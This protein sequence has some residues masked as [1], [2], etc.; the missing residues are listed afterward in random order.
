MGTGAV[1]ISLFGNLRASVEGV[2]I[3]ALA[4][5]RLQS[6]LAW[7]VLHADQ[8]APKEH[9][10]FLLWPE[11][12]GAQART[13]LRQLLHH[14][15]RAFPEC[16][17]LLRVD[18][19]TVQWR[20]DACCT[21]DVI[22]FASLVDLAS[23]A[24]QK[25][26]AESELQALRRAARL[27]VDDVMPAALDEWL[28]P[29]RQA[30]RT[31]LSGALLR[32]ASLVEKSGDLADAMTIAERLV[33]HEPT[34]ET[35]YQLL[36]R[37]QVANKDRASAVRT[38]HRCK[39]VLR[40]ELGM[41]P[42]RATVTL[43]EGL[44][45]AKVPERSRQAS[46]VQ[47]KEAEDLLIG[48]IPEQHEMERAWTSAMSGSAC[49]VLVSGE[50]GIGKTRLA[51]AFL[52]GA[53]RAGHAVVRSRCHVGHGQVAYAPVAQWLRSDRMR[54][55]WKGASPAQ[56]VELARLLPEISGESSFPIKEQVISDSW[57]KQHLY[58]ALGAAFSGIARPLILFVDDLHWCDTDSLEWLQ[59]MFTSHSAQRL[60]VI[61]TV[62]QE[63]VGRDHPLAALRIGLRQAD[64]LIDIPLRPLDAEES[65]K[66]ARQTADGLRDAAELDEVYRSTK[67]NPLFIVE[68]MRAGLQSTRIHAVISAR[69]ASLSGVSYELAGLA[70]V[71]GRSFSF[72]L[73]EKASDWDERSLSQALDELWQRRIIESR[74]GAEYDFTHDQLR[75]V[76]KL[77]LSPVRLRYVH[78][79]L[80]R[81][82]SEVYRNDIQEWNGQ[83]AFHYEQAGMVEQAIDHLYAA[84]G[85]ARH[86][87][88]Y[89]DSALLLRRALGLLEHFAE[90]PKRLER[91]LDLLALLGAALVTT[92]GY[93]AN[94]VGTTFRRAL[95][96][97]RR[98][99]GKQ[100]FSF[101][102]G[103][104]FFHVVRGEIEIS[105]QEAMEFLTAA[106][107]TSSSE[108]TLAGHFLLGSSLSH[109][110]QL[111]SS[112][113]HLRLALQ[114]HQE[115]SA[116]VLEVFGG[117]DARV[118]CQAYLSHLAWHRASNDEDTS[119]L[120]LVTDAV[121]IADSM[122]HPF[123]QAIALNYSALLHA[124]MSD[125][126][127]ALVV[128]RQAMELCNRN[129]FT[130]YLAMAS[131]VTA[132]AMCASGEAT[133][134]LEQFLSGLDVMR[135]LGAELRLPFY[136]ALLAQ[137]YGRFG[138]LREASASLATGFAFAGK[139]GE[140]WATSELH[141]IQG[142][143]LQAEGR[144]DQASVS[145]QRA[146]EAAQHCG[147]LAF[148][149]RLK[150]CLQRTADSN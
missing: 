142:D 99:G 55:C 98:L 105:R 4:T 146:L 90:S 14:L 80:A 61:G 25:D 145:Y 113:G 129:G 88:A 27:Y 138:M 8:P 93:S 133:A 85:L 40:R 69:L 127:S 50:P 17:S 103:Y 1:H 147:S 74:D 122:R 130:Y 30:M 81:A 47:G 68:T 32:L 9:L 83:I 31:Q 16:S 60:L 39:A 42:D 29:V 23:E 67:G 104:W 97:S 53:E 12:S 134:G 71:V 86:R 120:T 45:H 117:P 19:S 91:E 20:R 63:E 149:R 143:V 126:P 116:S 111:E 18:H 121:K 96:L 38:Y 24:K 89:R 128:G 137:S 64:V 22:E 76:A 49:A 33:G 150:H 35:S 112:Y 110:G 107:S 115:T 100:L 41:Q 3:A 82:L 101:L 52:Q 5:P 70:S 92:D 36:M 59:W 132:W 34:M 139:N 7:L 148:A 2:P 43:L 114:L 72:E 75:D 26:D 109:L 136:Y 46:A 48:R 131:I 135:S 124:L 13:N 84:A 58:S 108:L 56:K 57:Q 28:V 144:S 54:E 51:E 10:A 21:I 118:F 95:D 44:L 6:L 123:I 87:F 62:R 106:E 77:E 94:E 73:L 78:R 15:R 66:L 102:S 79:R 11:S 65:G 125:H 37:L 140:A 141:R 119:A